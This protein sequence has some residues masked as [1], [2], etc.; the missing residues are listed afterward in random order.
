MKKTLLIVPQLLG[1]LCADAVEIPMLRGREY[2]YSGKSGDVLTLSLVPQ[3]GANPVIMFIELNKFEDENV[4]DAGEYTDHSYGSIL[5]S[6]EKYYCFNDGEPRRG[7]SFLSAELKD[8]NLDGIIDLRIESFSGSGG[9]NFHYCTW[10]KDRF[11]AWDEANDLGLNSD[12]DGDRINNFRRGGGGHFHS[13]QYQIIK[14][15]FVLTSK[16]ETLSVD[17]FAPYERKLYPSF[18]NSENFSNLLHVES[19]YSDGKLLKRRLYED[20]DQ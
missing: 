17:E 15:K 3:P 8:F 16:V 11:V 14:G 13:E 18:P 7:L 6:G 5:A 10:K 2:G 9:S 4:A 1:C 20:K 12:L 19:I